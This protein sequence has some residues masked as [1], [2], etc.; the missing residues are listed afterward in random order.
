MLSSRRKRRVPVR[1]TQ[2]HQQKEQQRQDQQEKVWKDESNGKIVRNV[3]DS[4]FYKI[5]Y[6]N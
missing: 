2:Q 4:L 1:C 3:L 6:G 5:Q